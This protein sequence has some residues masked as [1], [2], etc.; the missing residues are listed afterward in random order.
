[1]PPIRA[2]DGVERRRA[3][4][5]LHLHPPGSGTRLGIDRDEDGCLDGDPA[6]E[7]AATSCG[8]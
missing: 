5:D 2:A 6:L 7:D 1:L 3:E 4:A 8:G